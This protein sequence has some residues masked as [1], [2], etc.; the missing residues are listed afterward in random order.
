MSSILSW[1][2]LN[3]YKTNAE[4]EFNLLSYEKNK[5]LMVLSIIP[6]KIRQC[7]IILNTN[8]LPTFYEP[9]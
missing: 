3:S 2:S 9:T 4:R 6:R 1:N 7:E 5:W 8:T